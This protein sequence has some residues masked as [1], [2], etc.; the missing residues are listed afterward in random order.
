M[1]FPLTIVQIALS[2]TTDCQSGM[3]GSSF[4]SA[5]LLSEPRPGGTY[6]VAL[7]AMSNLPALHKARGRLSEAEPLCLEALAGRRRILG[8]AHPDTLRTM[9]NLAVL[10]Q[11]QEKFAEAEP[12]LSKALDFRR[13]RLRS[14][15]P[16]LAIA[17]T[18]LRLSYLRLGNFAEAE[19][20]FV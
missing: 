15:D 17:L 16:Q 1:N 14:D 6:P 8:E 20:I 9:T 18:P 4:D 2:Q 3:D 13:P 19:L 12:L 7:I 10:Y 11:A 5:P